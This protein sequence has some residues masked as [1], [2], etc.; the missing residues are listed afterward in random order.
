MKLK[1][2]YIIIILLV[3]FSALSFILSQKKIIDSDSS[4][5]Y[6]T[7]CGAY[8]N[9][10]I[11]IGK[12]VINAHIADSVCKNITG[13]SGKKDLSSDEGMLF[14]FD[15]SGNNGFW[16]KDMNFSIDILWI[17][18]DFS[19]LGIE[20][21]LKPGTY[22]QVFGQNYL[23]KYVLELPAGISDINNIKVGDKIIFL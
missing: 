4:K 6:I 16:M 15:K 21:S 8:E 20:K 10:A 14:I 11:L 17:G 19:I 23:S 3:L 5:K 2:L 9:K 1:N 22:P 13:L 7:L 12:I 18:E